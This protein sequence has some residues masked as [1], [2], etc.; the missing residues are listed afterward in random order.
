MK[1]KHA[2]WL[3]VVALALSAVSVVV[4]IRGERSR[5]TPPGRVVKLP[6][7]DINAVTI[8]QGPQT[9]A[10]F[11]FDKATRQWRFDAPGQ[12]IRHGAADRAVVEDFL[13]F[14][15]RAEHRPAKVTLA[16][17]GLEDLG[18]AIQVVYAAGDDTAGFYLGN[19][20]PD[21]E[22]RYFAA[23]SAMDQPLEAPAAMFRAFIRAPGLYRTHDV[24][25]LADKSPDGMRLTLDGREIALSQHE[26]GWVVTK[27][28]N[29]P[30]ESEVVSGLLQ[31]FLMMRAEAFIDKL[32]AGA[33]PAGQVRLALRDRE[34]VVDFSF[35]PDKKQAFAARAGREEICVIAPEALEQL[36]HPQLAEILRRRSLDLFPGR[37][38]GRL[39]IADGEGQTLELA[40]G[41]HG[42]T[43]TP[44][45][46]PAFPAEESAVS[47]LEALMHQLP[48]NRVAAETF[49]PARITGKTLR[50][51]VK[52]FDAAGAALGGVE[53]T[54]LTE[55]KDGAPVFYA[56]VSGRPQMLELH[57]MAGMQ[58]LQPFLAYRGRALLSLPFEAVA[59]LKIIRHI[60]NGKVV[61]YERGGGAQ[62]RRTL[63]QPKELGERAGWEIL[64][65]ARQLAQLR[66]EG[67]LVEKKGNFAVY[68]LDQPF[69]TTILS[70]RVSGDG[71]RE[72]TLTIGRRL[73]LGAEGAPRNF[74]SATLSS[75][76][77]IFILNEKF[78]DRLLVDY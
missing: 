31:M 64:E 7:A 68:G 2:T 6:P 44:K 10:A 75:N 29:W 15:A 63:P 13:H 8:Y 17:A 43:A 38:A 27:P 76:D 26:G 12:G 74:Y 52:A 1:L 70:L 49:E 51:S 59:G 23:V 54:A 32:P 28:F 50:G 11:T 56:T 18:E 48:L 33:A 71:P 19:L 39:V 72:E 53:V 46:G 41:E 66:C 73:T 78:V 4:A 69:L 35:S 5:Y 25:D 22:T 55:T 21:G 20:S 61:A 30:A 57:P 24:F 47:A 42:W 37:K 67:Y 3:M 36:R 58:L 62:F 9:L 40:R 77:Y 16:Q 65:L 34:Q 45:G 14:A 60:D